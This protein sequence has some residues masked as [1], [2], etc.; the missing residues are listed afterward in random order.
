MTRP[1]GGSIR[2]NC[3]TIGFVLQWQVVS[4]KEISRIVKD[5]KKGRY[6]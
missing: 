4:A 5:E 1:K 2:E 6:S 3:G